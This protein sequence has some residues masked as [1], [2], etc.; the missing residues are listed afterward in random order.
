MPG[1]G[2]IDL[3]R[4]NAIEDDATNLVFGDRFDRDAHATRGSTRPGLADFDRRITNESSEFNGT[5]ERV[6]QWLN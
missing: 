4:D 1:L 5:I 6:S 3:S 2:D